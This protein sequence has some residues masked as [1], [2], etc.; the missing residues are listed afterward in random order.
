MSHKMRIPF[1]VKVSL[2]GYFPLPMFMYKYIKSSSSY[3]TR[4]HDNSNT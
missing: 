1:I 3:F 2:L 4:N